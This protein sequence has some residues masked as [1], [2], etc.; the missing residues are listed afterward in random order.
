MLFQARGRGGGRGIA[1]ALLLCAVLTLLHRERVSAGRP[2][3]V[4]AVVRDAALVPTQTLLFGL[5]RWWTGHVTALVQGPRLAHENAR[6]QAEVEALRAE[7]TG[8]LAAQAENARLRRALDFQRRSPRV[9]LA[10]EVVALKPSPQTDTLILNRGGGGVHPQEVVLSPD[11]ALVGQVLDVS[12]HSCSVLMLTDSGSA[13]GAE[14]V[15]PGVKSGQGTPLIGI[16]RGDRAGRLI[17]T[18]PRIDADVRPGDR[19]VTS[20]LGTVFPQ[21]LPLGTV[22]SVSADKTRSV[23]TATV[24]PAVDFD[25]LEEAF[26]AP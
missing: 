24:R 22:I 9:L 25:H 13:A 15:R 21:G 12:A 26:L 8:L 4:V 23:K 6:L 18:L 17:L 1:A 3:P 2:D 20:G 11:G 19:V 5:S 14:V 7:N 10:A 16:C